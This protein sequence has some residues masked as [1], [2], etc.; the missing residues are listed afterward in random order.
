MARPPRDGVR[1]VQHWAGRPVWRPRLSDCVL[2]RAYDT[3]RARA[4]IASPG[5]LGGRGEVSWLTPAAP[6]ETAY[7]GSR[8]VASRPTERIRSSARRSAATAGE[9][10]SV[11]AA[12]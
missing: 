1:V 11:R 8:M 10:P 4:R 12:S 6:R 7:R 9:T 2:Q 5:P 3:D